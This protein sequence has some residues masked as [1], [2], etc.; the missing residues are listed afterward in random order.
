FIDFCFD[1]G[2]YTGLPFT[3]VEGIEEVEKR[4]LALNIQEEKSE[5]A[6]NHTLN[7]WRS[8]HIVSAINLFFIP[9]LLVY[10][11]TGK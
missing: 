1:Q 11:E 7:L 3:S 10:V 9:Q 6:F 5:M 4:L 8:Q 2:G